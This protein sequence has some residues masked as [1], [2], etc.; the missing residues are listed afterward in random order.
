M[1]GKRK[2]RLQYFALGIVVFWAALLAV[3]FSNP[4]ETTRQLNRCYNWATNTTFP[5]KKLELCMEHQTY[6][7]QMIDSVEQ[8]WRHSFDHGIRKEIK[9]IRDIKPA[10]DSGWLQPIVPTSSYML[11]TM[12]YSFPFAVPKTRELIDTI[13]LRFQEKLSNTD[14]AGTRMV[15][16]SVLRTRSSVARLRRRNRNAIRNSA[17]L[18]GTT[19]DLS[20]ATYDFKRPLSEAE[21]HYLKEMLAATLF[22]LR[23]EKKCWVTYE[24]FQTCFH[25][26][27]R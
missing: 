25:V 6:A 9:F 11:D 24:Y 21:T 19:F 14:L 10:V 20:Y 17:H 3:F 4:A 18:H 1:T 2:K 23:K 8:Y 26:V 13:A 27:S 5:R 7:W 15:V 16:T 22:E 12:W